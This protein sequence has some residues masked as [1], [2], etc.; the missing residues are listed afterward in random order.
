MWAKA[1]G[2]CSLCS[3][4]VVTEGTETDD[5]AVFGEEAHIIG[6]SLGGPRARALPEIELNNYRNLILLCAEHHKQVDDQLN[7]FTVERLRQIK[8][9]HEQAIASLGRRKP[10]PVALVHDHDPRS[11][12]VHASISV[13]G[14]NS[15]DLLPTYVP[16]DVDADLRTAL[17]I[18]EAQG[19]FLL[20]VGGSSVGK[21]RSAYEAVTAVLPNWWLAYP[22][23]LDEIQAL[24]AA[25]S[26]RTV[27][28][29]DDMERHLADGLTAAAIRAL[30]RPRLPIVI[31]GSLWPNRYWTYAVPP[32]PD[33]SSDP[34][35]R[36]RELLGLAQ[37]INVAASFTPAERC[38]ADAI[39]ETD[40]RIR[41]ALR[42]AGYGMTQVLA[43]APQLVI[44]WE[45]PSTPYAGAIITAAID[46][47]RM[48]ARSP[49]TADLLVAAAP[50]YLTETQV[51]N[52]HVTWFGDAVVYATQELCGAA[53]VLSKIPGKEMGTTVGYEV[54]D[55]LLQY[56]HRKRGA[57]V[58]PESAWTAYVTHLVD[59]DDLLNVAESAKNRCL[60]RHEALL[61]RAAVA[62]NIPDARGKL[63]QMIMEQERIEEA[64][65]LWREAIAAGESVARSGLTELLHSQGR[66]D[67][68]EQ[69]WRDAV[70]A[71][72]PNA[73][74]RLAGELQDQERF[75]E[76][77]QLWREA[78]NAGESQS[79]AYLAEL[80]DECG[81]AE[82][83]EQVRRE[84]AAAGDW[85]ARAW[86]A[87]K[88]E[89]EGQVEAAEQL[90]R[91]GI[92]A[93]DWYAPRGLTGL[94]QNQGRAEEAEQF[95]RDA[96]ATDTSNANVR[97]VEVLHNQ[98]RTEEAEEICRNAI[99]VGEPAHGMLARLLEAQERAEE[100]EQ[101]WRAAV[102]AGDPTASFLLGTLLTK[103]GR[104]EAAEQVLRAGTASGHLYA[105]QALMRL[106]KD[107]G[108]TDGARHLRMFGLDPDGSPAARWWD[109]ADKDARR[110]RNGAALARK[111]R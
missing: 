36:Q 58:P 24:A 109:D 49:I 20:L 103:Q 105:G 15:G 95:W 48:G 44:R 42:S 108:R 78:V 45:N 25:P 12:G 72:E 110:D 63:A 40:L 29:L 33:R 91:Q 55:Y 37:I 31:I 75:E 8:S 53:S 27:I 32:S 99:A 93:G 97:L 9:D 70:A 43:A 14:S 41:I 66:T 68:A 10:A 59:P 77:E 69:Q 85:Q 71:S 61:Y 50:G 11:L 76:A 111:S 89:D 94:L 90:W 46:A 74:S 17:A 86:L 104:A 5:P 16:R 51:A 54:A 28:W 73:H 30:R 60:F 83:A 67:E 56:G 87:G 79:H 102:A 26:P 107:Q 100:A 19:C 57:Q 7:H 35:R 6:R 23:D 39:A 3:R 88:L 92:E 1:G 38:R 4:Q 98:G 62:A 13:P 80:L 52:A 34:Y 106:L 82:E 101:E 18:G 64:E 81:R 96:L 84:G 21:T 47:R 65:R 2:R 22:A